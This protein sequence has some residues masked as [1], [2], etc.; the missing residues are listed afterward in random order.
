[1]NQFVKDTL[2]LFDY[3]I[4][5]TNVVG[6][7]IQY[8]ATIMN[9]LNAIRKKHD[10]TFTSMPAYAS[11]IDDQSKMIQT[12]YEKLPTNEIMLQSSYETIVKAHIDAYKKLCVRVVKNAQYSIPPIATTR[13]APT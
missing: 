8:Y 11:I 6:E 5:N 13:V 7:R 10:D 2:F 12:C 9:T 3:H 4:C 1:M